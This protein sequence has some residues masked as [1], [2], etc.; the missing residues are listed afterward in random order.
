MKV[1]PSGPLLNSIMQQ[2]DLASASIQLQETDRQTDKG[3]QPLQQTFMWQFSSLPQWDLLPNICASV[4]AT[5]KED[6]KFKV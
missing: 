4:F 6:H 3:V 5:R 2:G 1:Q